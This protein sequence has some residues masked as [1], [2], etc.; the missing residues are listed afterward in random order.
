[1]ILPDYAGYLAAR[2]KAVNMGQKQAIKAEI[3]L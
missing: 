1:M 2:R 3:D